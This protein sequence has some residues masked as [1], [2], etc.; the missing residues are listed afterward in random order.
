MQDSAKFSVSKNGLRLNDGASK[1]YRSALSQ[2]ESDSNLAA[3]T[4]GSALLEI[5]AIGGEPAFL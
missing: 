5:K 1:S 2:K 4:G 3:I